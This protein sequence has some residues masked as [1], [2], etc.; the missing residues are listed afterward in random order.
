MPASGSKPVRTQDGLIKSRYLIYLYEFIFFR[1][2]KKTK[3]VRDKLKVEA[4]KYEKEGDSSKSSIFMSA[5]DQI[6]RDAESELF[7]T[8]LSILSISEKEHNEAYKKLR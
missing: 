6:W 8:V 7:E 2:Y 1:A 5:R 4:L 3:C